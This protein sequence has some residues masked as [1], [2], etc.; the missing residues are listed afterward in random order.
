MFLTN[1]IS[2]P[3]SVWEL[4]V[5][6]TD[7]SRAFDSIEFGLHLKK[8]IRTGFHAKLTDWIFSYLNNRMLFVCYNGGIPDNFINTSGVP[9]DSNVG[10]SLLI[11]LLMIIV[12]I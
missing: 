5:I 4:D 8:L 3:E 7:F 9:Q 2:S 10:I 12:Q 6:S 1:I 11:L